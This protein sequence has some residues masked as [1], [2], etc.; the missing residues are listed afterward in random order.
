MHC[1]EIEAPDQPIP[2]IVELFLCVRL[3]LFEVCD[4]G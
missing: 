4:E 1:Q 3:C 2:E